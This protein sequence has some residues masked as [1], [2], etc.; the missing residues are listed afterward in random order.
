[1]EEDRKYDQVRIDKEASEQQ[2]RVFM[3]LHPL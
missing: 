3:R 1:M 2:V